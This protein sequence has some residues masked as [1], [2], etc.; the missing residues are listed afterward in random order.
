MNF[1]ANPA[2]MYMNDKGLITRDRQTKKDVFYLYKSW[3][4]HE[5]E[6]V[7][8]TGRRL[9]YRPA[10]QSFTLTVYSNAP[11][12]KL[13]RDG[14]EVASL[15]ASG[16]G[17]GSASGIGSGSGEPTGVIW[18]F[19]DVTMGTGDTTFKVVSPSGTVDEVTW[20]VL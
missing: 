7:Y 4:N 11:S 13:Y 12:L 20:K 2:R 15:P 17:S 14:E 8:I 3:W 18:K 10:G 16:D 5:V 19:P 6:T 1:V 9:A